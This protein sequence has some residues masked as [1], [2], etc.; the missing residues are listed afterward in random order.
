[1]IEGLDYGFSMFWGAL[2]H[3]RKAGCPW[4]D[5]GRRASEETCSWVL[6]WEGGGGQ[7]LCQLAGYRAEVGCKPRTVAL[8]ASSD[9]IKL[10]HGTCLSREDGSGTAFPLL[11]ES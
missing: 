3:K 11:L 8:Q 1:M 7:G 4:P 9:C 6:Q 2:Q 10:Q 5:R